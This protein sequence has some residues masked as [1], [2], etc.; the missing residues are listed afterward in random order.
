MC[1]LVCSK[2]GPFLLLLDDGLKFGRVRA[3][4]RPMALPFA[5]EALG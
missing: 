3:Y 4:S 1:S 5:D 2:V